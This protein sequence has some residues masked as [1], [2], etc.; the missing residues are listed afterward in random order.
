MKLLDHYSEFRRAYH[1]CRHCG[2]HGRGAAMKNGSY[3]FQGHSKAV[4]PVT[5]ELEQR[6]SAIGQKQ[7]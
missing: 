2:W 5:A 7:T 4:I 6:T 3:N 1:T